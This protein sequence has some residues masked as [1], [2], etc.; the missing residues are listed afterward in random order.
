MILYGIASAVAGDIEDSYRSRAE[1]EAVL[2]GILRDEP[3]FE[4][5]CGSRRSN[6]TRALIESVDERA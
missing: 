4:D 1:A 2:V 6:S 3:E 5:C